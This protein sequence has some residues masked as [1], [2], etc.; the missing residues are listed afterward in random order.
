MVEMPLTA[1]ELRTSP[2]LAILDFSIAFRKADDWVLRNESIFSVVE[3]FLFSVI[4][5]VTGEIG[6]PELSNGSKLLASLVFQS[7]KLVI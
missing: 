4:N 7:L 2:M 6:L 5:W 3:T 1:D